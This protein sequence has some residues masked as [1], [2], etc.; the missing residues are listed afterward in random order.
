MPRGR[1]KALRMVSLSCLHLSFRFRKQIKGHVLLFH[2]ICRI[3]FYEP[4]F[5][6]FWFVFLKKL[7]P[8]FFV[9]VWEFLLPEPK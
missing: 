2:L 8:E 9:L 6:K 3:V 7:E 1:A 4:E 5:S